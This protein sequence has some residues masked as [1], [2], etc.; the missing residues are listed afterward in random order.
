MTTC[1]T[2][3]RRAKKTSTVRH[4]RAIQRDRSKRPLV[5]P[6]D[7]AITARLTEL[8]Y[9]GALLGVATFRQ[10]GLR[11]RTLTLPVMVA[12][13]VSLIWRQI[14]SVSELARVVSREGLL[15]APPVPISQQALS[16]RLRGLP[17]GLF[18]E[19][20]TGLLPVLQARWHE[21]QRPLPLE[22]AWARDHYPAVLAVDGS[23]LDALLRRVGLLRDRPD[24]PL[25]GR[26]TALLD[27][28]SHLPRQIWYEP[29]AQA[30]DQRSWPSIQAA[31][32][33]GALL[34]FDLGYTHFEHFA[35][36]TAAQITFLTRAKSNLAYT[37]ERSLQ[38]T[39]QIEDALIWIGS[40]RDRQLVRRCAVLYQGT[41]YRYLTNERDPQRLPAVYAATLYGQRW[42]IEDAYHLVK[43]LLG[44]AY[45]WVG[46]ENGVTLQL[47][48]T[49]L[50][51]AVLVD[52]TDAVAEALTQ[53]LAALSIE[54]TYRGLYYFARAAQRGEATDPVAFLAAEAKLLGVLKRKRPAKPP[55][56][57]QLLLTTGPPS[58]TCD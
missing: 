18:A 38:H 28:C 54:M 34:V 24:Q 56:S 49:W 25:A 22:L 21:R 57:T 40:G 44:L 31:V 11:E 6:P 4:T 12:L 1:Q 43:R 17:A 2:P 26:M 35:A 37:V 55:R 33:A 23:T 9:L 45:F 20:L 51:Y 48:A 30:H 13:V 47:W 14:G 3:A 50:L 58:L 7:E 8:L 27:L 36:L 15:W 5:A 39:P 16:Q 29:D 41:W 46:S 19:V 10:M 32:P 53:P 42:R 52:L